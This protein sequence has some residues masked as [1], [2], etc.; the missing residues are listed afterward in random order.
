MTN[1]EI[2]SFL[3]VFAMAVLT[4]MVLVLRKNMRSFEDAVAKL[5]VVTAKLDERT[6]VVSEEMTAMRA[7]IDYI[8]GVLNEKTNQIEQEEKARQLWEDGLANILNYSV[9]KAKG[10]EK[11]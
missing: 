5:T 2:I 8:N 9:D 3:L 7:N 4:V 11:K 10:G 1:Y 6:S